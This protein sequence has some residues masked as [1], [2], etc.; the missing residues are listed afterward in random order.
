[1]KIATVCNVG[2]LHVPL[3]R[4]RHISNACVAST[5]VDFKQTFITS[6]L[7]Q[8]LEVIACTTKAVTGSKL[9]THTLHFMTMHLSVRLA[10]RWR[11]RYRPGTTVPTKFDSSP[12]QGS[13]FELELAYSFHVLII[14]YTSIDEAGLH[15]FLPCV[16]VTKLTI[17][18]Q[19]SIYLRK[20]CLSSLERRYSTDLSNSKATAHMN[21][22]S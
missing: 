10:Q 7:S 5:V 11:K 13:T 16:S 19:E 9:H 8:M 2:V 22:A 17:G 12:F 6:R 15:L 21:F 1:M 14:C 4:E 20:S 18:E 3:I